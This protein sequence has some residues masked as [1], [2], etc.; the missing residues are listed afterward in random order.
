MQRAAGSTGGLPRGWEVDISG[1]EIK[2][3]QWR[4]ID[5]TRP[6]ARTVGHTD[7]CMAKESRARGW[8]M[9]AS[10]AGE[11]KEDGGGSLAAFIRRQLSQPKNIGLSQ[12]ANC[13]QR[14]KNLSRLRCDPSPRLLFIDTTRPLFFFFSLSR[15]PLSLRIHTTSFFRTFYRPSSSGFS[16]VKKKKKKRGRHRICALYPANVI[17]NFCYLT[18]R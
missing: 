6:E 16:W 8:P 14:N 9:T 15:G 18:T 5:K 1:Y 13:L 17:L 11:E 3:V 2:E 10:L 4:T 7:H 12:P